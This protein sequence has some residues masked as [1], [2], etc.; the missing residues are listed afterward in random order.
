M[1]PARFD[2][3]RAA[4]VAETHAA[5]AEFGNDARVIAGGQTLLP[6]LSM[7]LVRPKIVVDIMHLPA[8]RG[9]EASGNDIRVG[10]GV[11]Q[12]ELLSW[13]GLAE[14][15][16][17]LS[18]AL[19]W[20][21]H[22]QTRSRGTVCGSVAH[23]DPSAEIPLCL[24]AL[25]ATIELSSRGGRRRVKAAEFFTGMMTTA[26]TDNELIEAVHIPKKRTGTGYA[27]QEFGRRHGDFAI[28]A[29]AA[30]ITDKNVRLVIGGVADTPA[31]HDFAALDGKALNEALDAFAWTLDA[32]EDLH[33]T[34]RYRR[35]LVR[36]MGRAAIEEARACRA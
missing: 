36:Q 34:A 2:Y 13:P 20:V 31:R 4:D 9:I 35:E 1:K 21:G 3:I 23:A 28:V 8:L 22:A 16:P 29:C 5:L 12:A 32:R 10:A 30:I 25:D 11:R 19:P 26:R 6:M 18:A 17:L 33:A 14:H 24:L 7:R 27:F 15:L